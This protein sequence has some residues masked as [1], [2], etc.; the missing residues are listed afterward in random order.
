MN[1]A[2]ITHPADQH[3]PSFL[4]GY[5]SLYAQNPRKATLEWFKQSRYGLFIHYGLYSVLGHGE[6]AM[7]HEKI[8]H[9][10]YSKLM[11]QFTAENFDADAITDLAIAADMQYITFTTRHHEGFSLFNTKQSDYN[12][13]QAPC[14]RD[15][16]AELTMACE[17]KKIGLFLYYSYSADW[18]HPYFYPRVFW[19][20]AQPNYSEPDP[21]YLWEKDADFCHYMDFVHAQLRELLTQYGP[22][23]GLW[24]DPITAYHCRPDL[25]AIDET[26]ALI[27][28]LQPQ[29]LISFKQGA[30][31]EED[32]AA[33][34]R[35]AGDLSEKLKGK[36]GKSSL[37]AWEKN[38]DKP[39]EICETLQPRVWGYNKYNDGEHRNVDDVLKCYAYAR[40]INAKVLL[41]TGPLPDGSIDP[42]DYATLIELGKRLR[43]GV[44]WDS[45]DAQSLP[46]Q[47]VHSA[48]QPTGALAE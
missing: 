7:F 28:S 45:I 34:E 12:S 38:K 15:L 35:S 17:K 3:I 19:E 46:L 25:F 13:V 42:T 26:Y 27:R 33:P 6:W 2:I 14:G 32:Y 21:R 23:A 4:K 9:S 44:D 11:D 40:S 22:I 37:K 16:V 18:Q 30:N 47:P 24:F 10:R 43:N 41:N 1:Q 36:A 29:C 20:P 5:E 39:W 8:P 31:G 48:N